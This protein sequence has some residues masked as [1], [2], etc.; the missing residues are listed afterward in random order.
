MRSTLAACAAVDVSR[1]GAVL[2]VIPT[3]CRQG[4]LQLLGPFLVGLGEPP[5]LIGS[6][7]K[8]TEHRAERLAVVDRVEEL[9][10]HLYGEPRLCI[11]RKRALAASFCASRHRSQSQPSS[12]RVRVPYAACGP[13]RRPW[14]SVSSRIWC[15]CCS[16]QGGPGSS[17]RESHRRTTGGVTLHMAAAWRIEVTSCGPLTTRTL[18]AFTVPRA[19][20]PFLAQIR[21]ASSA[22]ARRSPWV[23]RGRLPPL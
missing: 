15:N 14:G 10:P 18:A 6:Q 21:S 5:H 19:A 8:V 17:P 7:A 9:L 1:V 2:E 22:R 16:V 12:Q 20:L 3:G 13:R 4:S 23:D 11:R